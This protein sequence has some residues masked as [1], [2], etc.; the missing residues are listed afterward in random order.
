MTWL[1]A[2]D[3]RLAALWP[4]AFDFDETVRGVYLDAARVQCEEYLGADR[5]AAAGLD[6]PSNWVLAQ[7]QQARSLSMAATVNSNDELGGFGETFA[8][9]P[10]DWKVINLLRPKQPL[11]I[12]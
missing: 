3:A 10:M 8:I 9:F 6:I 2:D 5:L 11:G 4:G 12:A 1:T 7:V